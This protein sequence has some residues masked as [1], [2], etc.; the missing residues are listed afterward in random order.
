MNLK[1]SWPR[2]DRI[3]W[4]EWKI[5]Q[6]MGAEKEKPG[7]ARE[8]DLNLGREL[9]KQGIPDRQSLEVW[10]AK[11]RDDRSWRQIV[12]K[13][14]PDY[15]KAKHVAAGISQ[16]RRCHAVVERALEPQGRQAIKRLLDAR[17]GELFQCTPETFKR[18]LNSI[19]TPRKPRE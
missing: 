7:E 8:F 19:K 2:E 6:R 15:V 18:Y 14:F 5:Q 17:I 1:E 4:V 3:R 9:D 10:L 16:A 11:E 12:I 13:Y